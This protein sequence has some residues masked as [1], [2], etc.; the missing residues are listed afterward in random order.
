M[1]LH[2]SFVG[3][4]RALNCFQFFHYFSMLIFLHIG[5]PKLHVQVYHYDKYGRSELYGYGFCFIPS[6]P[7]NHIVECC[8][9]RPVGM[10]K[11]GSLWFFKLLRNTF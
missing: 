5:W 4:L 6:T 10:C 1:L 3:L 2:N 8:T 7:G 9:W 11:S